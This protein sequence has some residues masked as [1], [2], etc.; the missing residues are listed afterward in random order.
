MFTVK[1][2]R[3][4]LEHGFEA[5]SYAMAE[6]PRR[7]VL[8]PPPTKDNP[9][10]NSH[11]LMLQDA[12]KL[13]EPYDRVEILNNDGNKVSGYLRVTAEQSAQIETQMSKATKQPAKKTKKE[14]N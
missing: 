10:P 11:L 9:K 3:G 1:A 14:M 6:N 12:D 2:H 5:V 4:D 8:D 7:V 13:P